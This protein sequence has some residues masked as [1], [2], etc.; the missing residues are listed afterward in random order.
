MG[1][2]RPGGL[3]PGEGVYVQSVGGRWGGLCHGIYF[4]GVNLYLA[5]V[6]LDFSNVI[7]VS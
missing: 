5:D 2:L 4:T 3:C 7:P 6:D 1:S